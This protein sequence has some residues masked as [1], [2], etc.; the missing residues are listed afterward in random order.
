MTEHH[1]YGRK[2]DLDCRR[3]RAQEQLRRARRTSRRRAC[4]MAA[5]AV[6]AAGV[7]LLLTV[8]VPI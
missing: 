2:P 8:G 7:G 3:V 5:L 4:L 1:F 6:S